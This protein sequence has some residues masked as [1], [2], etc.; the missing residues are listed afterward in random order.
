MLRL[1][2]FI[3]I[4]IIFDTPN[5]FIKMIKLE[6]L[7]LEHRLI[8][9]TQ[10]IRLHEL[11]M[12]QLSMWGWEQT[13]NPNEPYCLCYESDAITG[14]PIKPF[15]WTAE[16]NTVYAAFENTELDFILQSMGNFPCGPTYKTGKEV[17]LE[18]FNWWCDD[19][20]YVCNDTDESFHA[21]YGAW[22]AQAKA[23][24]LIQLL[25]TDGLIPVDWIYY[26]PDRLARILGNNKIYKFKKGDDK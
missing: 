2:A 3:T 20:V 4:A 21:A 15:D 25:E 9:P 24:K 14:S 7:H 17:G 26:A 19:I 6:E 11:G 8:T 1:L 10:A 18:D 13:G 5:P 12:K 16:P 22:P 23:N